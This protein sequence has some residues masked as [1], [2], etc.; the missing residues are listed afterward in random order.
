[1]GQ[2]G[3]QP[4]FGTRARSIAPAGN[5]KNINPVNNLKSAALYVGT[6]GTLICQ[7]VGGNFDFSTG[8]NFTI[9]K[10]IP[11]GTFLPIIVDYVFQNDDDATETTCSDIIALY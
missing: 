1:M 10:N 7:V 4:D 5:Y 2:Y 8:E 6:G 11:N 9:F 3:N